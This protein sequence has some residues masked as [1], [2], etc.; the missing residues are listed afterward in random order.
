MKTKIITL[1]ISSFFMLL[2]CSNND[3]E[4]NFTAQNI[5]PELIGKGT[6]DGNGSENIS[7]QNIVISTQTQ[8]DNLIS[9]MNTVNNVSDSFTQT[10]VDFN[11]FMLIA[12]FRS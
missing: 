9:D 3:D 2:S 1:I 5:T 12:V 4:N 8:F 10:T 11:S 7:Q 6:L